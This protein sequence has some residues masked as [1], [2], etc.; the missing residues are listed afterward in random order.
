[1]ARRCSRGKRPART[2]QAAV[3]HA[4]WLIATALVLA[5][6]CTH[7]WANDTSEASDASTQSEAAAVT[8]GDASSSESARNDAALAAD[9]AAAPSTDAGTPQADAGS[10]EASN[11][12][13]SAFDATTPNPS[14]GG[15]QVVDS[16]PPRDASNAD[17]GKPVSSGARFCSQV[18]AAFC[19]DFEDGPT[20][21]DTFTWTELS[22]TSQASL[23]VVNEGAP[24]SQ[25][26]LKS[27]L[28]GA[29]DESARIAYKFLDGAPRWFR[30]RFDIRPQF[31]LPV[32]SDSLLFWFKLTEQSGDAYPGLSLASRAD[33]NFLIVQNYDGSTPESFDM[34]DVPE[35]P[36]GWFHVEIEVFTG[37]SGSI[38]VRFNDKIAVSYAG[39]VRVANVTQTFALLGIYTQSG[40]PS[41]AL[42][43]NV[44]IEF[45]Q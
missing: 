4:R 45:G 38:V 31:S 9:S 15:A 16:A 26:A 13:S 35:L 19:N 42:Y 5:S 34:Y 6:S 21:I 7:D 10:V 8:S 2:T 24:P 1:M 3:R 43:D 36:T 33:G 25:R 20:A 39:V 14:D 41:S 18:D 30:A 22:T 12:G 27:A 23:T 11:G 37:T 17:A 28:T 32:G 44:A 29:A 40:P